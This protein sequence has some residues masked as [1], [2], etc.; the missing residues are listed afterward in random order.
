MDRPSPDLSRRVRCPYC[1]YLMPVWQE[2]DAES[3]GIWVRCKGRNCKKLFEV[4]VT[5]TR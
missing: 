1:G 3:S 2:E 5:K 4:K